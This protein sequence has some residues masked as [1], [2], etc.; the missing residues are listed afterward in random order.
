MMPEELPHARLEDGHAPAGIQSSAVNDADASVARASAFDEVLH[1]RD[2]FVSLLTVQVDDV[3]CGVVAS[4]ELSEL[5]P[6]DTGRD[7]ALLRCFGIVM[8]C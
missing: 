4:L 5:A 8:I 2:G 3:V 6:I 1:V 7:V